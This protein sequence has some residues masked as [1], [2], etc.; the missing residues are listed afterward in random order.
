MTPR[1][2]LALGILSGG[3][4]RLTL[5][6]STT[7]T[8]LVGTKHGAGTFLGDEDQNVAEEDEEP[9]SKDIGVRTIR[10]SSR[11]KGL[12][13]RVIAMSV[14]YSSGEMLKNDEVLLPP[15]LAF[16]VGMSPFCL[17]VNL[18]R[19]NSPEQGRSSGEREAVH[20]LLHQPPPV[21]RTASV[22]AVKRPRPSS[23]SIN[24]GGGGGLGSGL[25][26]SSSTAKQARAHALALM[27]FFSTPRVLRVGDVFGV[28]IP[29][30]G[31]A[32][33]GGAG[34][35][36]GCWWQELHEDEHEN[37]EQPRIE[38]GQD[39]DTADDAAE[40]S[41]GNVQD[42]TVEI[43]SSSSSAGEH[44]AIDPR[45]ISSADFTPLSSGAAGASRTST[46]E[47]TGATGCIERA[48]LRPRVAELRWR[49]PRCSAEERRFQEAINRQGSDLV[50]FCV[51][52]LKG[53][54]KT[55]GTAERAVAASSSS[56]TQVGEEGSGSL[57]P[58]DNDGG[59]G[60]GGGH[61]DGFEECSMVVSRSATA[62]RQGPAVCSAV[63][64]TAWYHAFVCRAQGHPCSPVQPPLVRNVLV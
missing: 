7:T 35:G 54:G 9:R 47:D 12:L 55:A 62:L 11:A 58:L 61:V 16:N 25:G 38:E 44:G 21:A 41:W 64:E 37:D 31:F 52:G 42:P 23:G 1:C 45:E 4:G 39:S 59:L 18:R 49:R 36:E 13:C 20:C 63:P 50:Y 33:G 22:S 57:A 6:A 53:E 17:H 5:A 30:S 32:H 48:G 34:G 56:A 43:R 27:S 60:L 3:W 51:T 28:S 24:S 10:R 15:S 2:L 29:C 46:G 8:P 26:N 19:E 14:D 40:Y